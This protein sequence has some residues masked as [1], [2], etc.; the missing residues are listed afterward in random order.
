MAFSLTDGCISC[1]CSSV[2]FVR[3]LRFQKKDG[4]VFVFD[5][6]FF[7]QKLQILKYEMALVDMVLLKMTVLKMKQH[8]CWWP[9]LSVL[10]VLA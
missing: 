8:W 4:V 3:F 2:V 6:L 7:W 1:F 5:I 10:A 9:K